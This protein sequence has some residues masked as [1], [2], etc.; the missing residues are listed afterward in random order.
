MPILCFWFAC[1]AVSMDEKIRNEDKKENLSLDSMPKSC[2][3][4]SKSS[5]GKRQRFNHLSFMKTN[6]L[7]AS[8]RNPM[9][10]ELTYFVLSISHLCNFLCL[11]EECSIIGTNYSGRHPEPNNC[12][13][14]YCCCSRSLL[15]NQSSRRHR[16]QRLVRVHIP[17]THLFQLISAWP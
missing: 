16:I 7:C 15:I 2:A 9:H 13:E 11:L 3:N 12:S 5:M 1:L 4:V 8:L 17:L 6:Y 10:K 14:V